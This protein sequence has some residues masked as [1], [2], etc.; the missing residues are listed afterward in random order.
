MEKEKIGA[1]STRRGGERDLPRPS[2]SLA[3]HPEPLQQS[4]ARGARAKKNALVSS[5]GGTASSIWI[6]FCCLPVPVG[7]SSRKTYAFLALTA[8]AATLRSA[9]RLATICSYSAF[10]A[11]CASVLR[12]ASERR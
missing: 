7:K 9:R 4:E 5:T 10:W 6:S 2:P 8:E 11:F 3:K 12:R 1:F